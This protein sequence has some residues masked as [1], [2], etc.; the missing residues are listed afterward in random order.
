MEMDAAGGA[1]PESEP[2]S[3]IQVGWKQ[4]FE[5]WLPPPSAAHPSSER[6]APATAAAESEE[7]APKKPRLVS[8]GGGCW[9]RGDAIQAGEMVSPSRQLSHNEIAERLSA[10][11]ENPQTQNRTPTPDSASAVAMLSKRREGEGERQ[12]RLADQRP[13]SVP[14]FDQYVS[15]DGKIVTLGP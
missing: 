3:A 15:S 7:P 11:S 13:M 14:R 9:S 12:E 1:V 8:I 6:S 4:V 10:T 2:S 5:P